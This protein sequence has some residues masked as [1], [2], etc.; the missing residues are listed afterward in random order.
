MDQLNRS[1]FELAAIPDQSEEMNLL[2]ETLQLYNVRA[3]EI[4]RAR[5]SNIINNQF[6]ILKGA[7]GSNDIIIRDRSL[8]NRF[9]SLADNR[10]DKLFIFTNYGKLYRY[11]CKYFSHIAQKIKK[12]KNNKITHSFRYLNTIGIQDENT[13]KVLLHHGS[14]KSNHYYTNKI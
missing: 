7:K 11:C 10:K 3:C 1:F 6:L 4:L 2:I 9:V 14:K 8:V 13:I 12:K 5:K